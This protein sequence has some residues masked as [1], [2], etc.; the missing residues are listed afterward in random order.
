MFLKKTVENPLV[1][2]LLKTTLSG[3]HAVSTRLHP[4]PWP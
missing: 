2:N 3:F 1:V 4:L